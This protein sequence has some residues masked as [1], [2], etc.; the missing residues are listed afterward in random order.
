[1]STWNQ[2]N[3][4]SLF[5]VNK[6][7]HGGFLVCGTYFTVNTHMLLHQNHHKSDVNVFRHLCWLNT[8]I[9]ILYS[10]WYPSVHLQI[11]PTAKQRSFGTDS[12]QE[13]CK[14]RFQVY[15]IFFEYLKIHNSENTDLK[16]SDNGCAELMCWGV[17]SYVFNMTLSWHTIFFKCH[18]WLH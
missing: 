6:K 13:V 14:S 15:Y 4:K 10:S 1:M 12:L 16:S 9:S 18:P 5:K 7:I 17:I 3:R 11:Y 2:S 8:L